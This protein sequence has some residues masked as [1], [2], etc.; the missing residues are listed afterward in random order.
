MP[1]QIS[2]I[3]CESGRPIKV[4][5]KDRKILELLCDDARMPLTQVAKHVQLSRDAIS[6][7][8][9]RLEKLGVIQ[10][11]IPKISILKLGYVSFHILLLL[12]ETKHEKQ[13]ELITYLKEHPNVKSIMEYTGRWDYEVIIFTRNLME[14]DDFVTDLT[15]KFFD[16][17]LEK[18][19]IQH[20]K[21]YFS[22]YMPSKID[23]EQLKKPFQGTEVVTL[24]EIDKKILGLLSNDCRI[25]TYDMSNS[26]KLSPD[27]ISY[28][29]KKLVES[30]VINKFTLLVNLSLLNY[31]LYTYCIQMKTLTKDVEAKLKEFVRNHPH[32]MKAIKT[33]GPWNLMLYIVSDT[34]ETFHRVVHEIKREFA[35]YIQ[36]YSSWVAYKEHYFINI[37][38]VLLQ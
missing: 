21:T 12:D 2:R 14:F 8:I 20:I 10:A 23:I 38:Q 15:S 4:D 22:T 34:P 33:M 35:L 24:D 5:V 1:T 31:Q 19:V 30:E 11:F 26:I 17:I 7:R 6:Y 9:N 3:T 16:I 32:I 27:A 25:S 28:R 36:T 18:R 29:I 37:P 13:G